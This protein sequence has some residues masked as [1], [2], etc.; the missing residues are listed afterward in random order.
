MIATRLRYGVVR[1]APRALAWTIVIAASSAGAVRAQEPTAEPQDPAANVRQEQSAP[2]AQPSPTTPF[3]RGQ[4]ISRYWLRWTGN[5]NDSDL[6]ET[7]VLDVGDA[8][9]HA[10]TGHFYGRMAADLDGDTDGTA[11]FSSLQDVWDDNVDAQVYDAFVDLHR[12]DQLELV[13]IGRQ[14]LADTPEFAYFDGVHVRTHASG[15]SGLQFGAYGGLSTHHYESSHSGDL[16]AGLYGEFRPWQGGRLRIDWM[17]LEDEALLGPHS[18]DL[19][20]GG[21][22]HTFGV[23]QLEAQYSRIEGRDRDVRARAAWSAPESHLLAQLTWYQLLTTQRSQ[24]LE[25]DPFYN[26]LNELFPYWQFGAMVGKGI[27][28]Q[29]DVDAGTDVRRVSDNDDIGTFNR[30]YER[31]YVT[32]NVRDVLADGVTLSVTADYW[33]SDGQD[34][35]TWAGELA[36]RCNDQLTTSVGTYYSL[37]KFSLFANDERDHVR[38]YYGRLRY[39]ASRA[40]DLDL[41]Y[42]FERTDLDDFQVLRMGFTWHF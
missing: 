28:D 18:D 9:Q 39:A 3:V 33:D 16:T 1:P 7:L 27:V 26:S 15:T 25:L 21:V 22:W 11:P 34:V 23:A 40:T 30:D 5:Q 4:L 41:T 10:V 17:H 19:F 29:V 24:V 31:W 35:H 42:E 32:V 13:R 20:S 12:L 2:A 14:S 6:Y 38:T 8:T 36:K 37:Y